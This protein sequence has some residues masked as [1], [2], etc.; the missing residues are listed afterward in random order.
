MHMII[1]QVLAIIAFLVDS[2]LRVHVHV[3][4]FKFQVAKY[5]NK[6]VISVWNNMLELGTN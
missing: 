6:W 5:N 4:P 1:A 3:L 2:Q